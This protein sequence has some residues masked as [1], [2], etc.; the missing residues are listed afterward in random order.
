MLNFSDEPMDPVLPE[1]LARALKISHKH[2]P[3]SGITGYEE[4][5]EDAAFQSAFDAMEADLGDETLARKVDSRLYLLREFLKKRGSAYYSVNEDG[6]VAVVGELLEY[7]A[8][9]PL[10]EHPDEQIDWS[11]KQDA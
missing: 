5:E 10:T 3:I 4:D 1:M 2:I 8:T 11:P 7:A 9:G 6:G